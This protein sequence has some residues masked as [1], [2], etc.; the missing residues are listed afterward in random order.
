M[1]E[2][3]KQLGQKMNNAS[4]ESLETWCRETKASKQLESFI[5]KATLYTITTETGTQNHARGLGIAAW[6]E[7]AKLE[8]KHKSLVTQLG[9][10]KGTSTL[11]YHLQESGFILQEVESH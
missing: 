3:A 8:L 6:M 5:I 2:G 11:T 7:E 10:K 1:T 4:L 9:G